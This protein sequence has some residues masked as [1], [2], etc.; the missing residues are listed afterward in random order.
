MDNDILMQMFFAEDVETRQ[1]AAGIL[2]PELTCSNRLFYIDEF[3]KRIIES[4]K[5]YPLSE[6]INWYAYSPS[7]I[8]EMYPILVKYCIDYCNMINEQ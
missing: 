1:L 6:L 2:Q 4:Q 7:S 3:G 5:G 8:G